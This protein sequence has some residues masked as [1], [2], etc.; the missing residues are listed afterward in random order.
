MVLTSA[1]LLA[2][3]S[4]AVPQNHGAYT[5]VAFPAMGT[6]NALMFRAPS[7]A[8]ATGFRAEALRWLADFEARF[9][10]FILTSLVG[11][12]NAGAGSGAWVELDPAA[13]ELFA[14]CDWFHWKT[15]G[16]FDPTVGTVAR[17]WGARRQPAR[18]PTDA[19]VAAVLERVGWSKVERA[20]AKARLPRAGMELDLGGLGKEYAVD[21]I[22]A[23]S[24][25]WGCRDVLVDFGRDLR[26]GGHP[27]EGGDWRLGLEHPEQ[28]D[29]CWGGVA[30][31]DA[32]LC[33]SGDYRR[34][35]ELDGRRYGHL[36]D[37]RSGRPVQ[38]GVKAVWAIAPT[39]T[40]AGILTT[41]ACILGVEAGGK[42]F[43][44]TPGAAGCIWSEQGLFQT[45]RFQKY[46][47]SNIPLSA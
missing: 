16:V 25:R 17:L 4:A 34:Y 38:T 46:E 39:C 5:R 22:F 8:A 15:S 47:L 11:Q 10:R 28:P 31:T 40:E 44:Q 21:Q 19:E 26:V 6:Q 41:A 7:A 37:P 18:P 32:A 24:Q 20:H 35:T 23:F 27:P 14:L 36:V 45:R 1:D 33:C 42:L 9:S 12:L 30:L 13:Q 3:M 2:R 29:A 43:E